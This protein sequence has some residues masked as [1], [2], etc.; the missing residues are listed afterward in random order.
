V[1]RNITFKGMDNNTRPLIL[2]NTGGELVMETGAVITGNTNGG[3]KDDGWPDWGYN[4]GGGVM[5]SGGTFKMKDGATISHNTS[6]QDGTLNLG[7]G[8][9]GVV[10]GGTFIME[11]GSISGNVAQ[12][13][14]R[15]WHFGG[16]GGV[17]VYKGRFEMSGGSI[18]SNAAQGSD[19]SMFAKKGSGGGVS[20][21]FRNGGT[22]VKTGGSIGDNAND[23]TAD[24]GKQV[25]VLI[26]FYKN[27]V[28]G[29]PGNEGAY[30][31][32]VINAPLA[33]ERQLSVTDKD[34]MLKNNNW[35]DGGKNNF[36]DEVTYGT[37]TWPAQ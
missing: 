25:F 9:V 35:W 20:V 29:G 27:S 13:T 2:V 10:K 18:T 24:Q 34:T 33:E 32:R 19:I 14:D 3:A 6:K 22:F 15:T 4:S 21:S 8:G 1:L 37:P 28:Y 17:M 30:T 12:G 36:E 11:G 16:G 31:Y 23:N 26:E 7:G 5:V